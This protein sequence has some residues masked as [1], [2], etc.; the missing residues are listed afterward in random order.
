MDA[1]LSPK[2]LNATDDVSRSYSIYEGGTYA[3]RRSC[4]VQGLLGRWMHHH[5]MLLPSRLWVPP[6]PQLRPTY[7]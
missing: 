1:K 4:G 7:E 3:D 2:L 6:A 5:S